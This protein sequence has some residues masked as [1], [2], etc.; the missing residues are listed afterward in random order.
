MSKP[1]YYKN[2]MSLEEFF[3][4]KNIS[5]GN[6]QDVKKESINFPASNYA[7]LI[8]GR[9][10]LFMKYGHN[11]PSHA[12]PDKMNIEVVLNGRQLFKDLS[13]SGYGSK[14]C[15]EWHRT[16]ASHNTVMV[17]GENQISTEPGE[18]ISFD[19]KC[20]KALAR[21]VYPQ[22]DFIRELQFVDDGFLDKFEVSSL[23]KHT[24]DLIYHVLAEPIMSNEVKFE[25][26]NLGFSQNGYQYFSE[27]KKL[28]I[29][30][31]EKSLTLNWLFDQEVLQSK[32][33]V[34]GKEIYFCESPSNPISEYLPTIIIRQVTNNAKF[35]STWTRNK[36]RK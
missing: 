21:D 18:V 6:H 11:G 5:F 20:C 26:A 3:L 23:E 36:K 32:I 7:L 29:P 30:T 31:G 16:T 4:F 34:D 12:H 22:I 10:N 35:N 25:K 15:K 33:D 24:Y 19:G 9:D 27:V 1:Y 13:N 14:M 17:D 8:R 2:S 28:I